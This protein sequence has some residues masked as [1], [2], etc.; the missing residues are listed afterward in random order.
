MS[1]KPKDYYKLLN[2]DRDSD[3]DAIKKAYRKLA[4]KYHPDK[5]QGDKKAE[6]K[7]K[8]I[9]EAYGVL[10]DPDEKAYYDRTGQVKGSGGGRY[11]DPFDIFSSVFGDMGFNRGFNRGFNTPRRPNRSYIYKDN[12]FVYRIGLK[13]V[14]TGGVAKMKFKRQIACD[15]CKGAGYEELE[16]KCGDC[17]GSGMFSQRSQNMIFQTT[18]SKCGGY[19]REIKQ[20]DGCNGRGYSI[21]K[22]KI[23][24]KIPAGV[25]P[26]T[27]LKIKGKGNEI[28]EGDN[29]V[30]GDSYVVVDYPNVYEGVR[31]D[32]GDIYTSIQVPFNTILGEKKIKVNIFGCK[33]IEFKLDLNKNNGYQYKIEDAGVTENNDAFI[34]VFVDLPKNK[35]SEQDRKKLIKSMEEVYG[36][37]TDSFN[38]TRII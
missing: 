12:K 20:C 25:R 32:R 37:A 29:K 18:C 13:E 24:L 30:T 15:K 36:N 34:K 9:S 16:K 11:A 33:E 19:G 8:E 4:M 6:D 14:I 35:I 38:P 22:E 10:S 23:S 5:N 3:A 28:Y 27:S 7:F 31:L 17:N 26:L 2:V 21:K 1:K